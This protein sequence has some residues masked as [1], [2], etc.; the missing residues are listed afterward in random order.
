MNRAFG[1]AAAAMIFALGWQTQ[2]WRH[3][4]QSAQ[5]ER[6]IAQA[7][8]DATDTARRRE[9]ELQRYADEVSRDAAKRQTVLAA[10]VATTDRIAGQLRDDITRLNARRS[11]EDPAAARFADDAR[12]ARELLG[13]CADRYRGVAQAADD[14]RDRVIGLQDYVRGVAPQEN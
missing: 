11:H 6:E 13:A 2:S 5:R 3:E 9:Q 10:R 1:V 12:T 7:T 14:L 4:A 8:K